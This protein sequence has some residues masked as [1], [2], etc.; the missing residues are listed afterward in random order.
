MVDVG[1]DF[2]KVGLTGAFELIRR[3]RREQGYLLMAGIVNGDDR[4]ISGLRKT[5]F[6]RDPLDPDIPYGKQCKKRG[7]MWYAPT[8]GMRGMPWIECVPQDYIR[9]IRITSTL[10]AVTM[11]VTGCETMSKTLTYETEHGS[12]TV[13]FTNTS[14]TIHI[15]NPHH[16]TPN[17]PHVYSF[18][19]R[20]GEDEIS[21]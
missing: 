12:E 6:V 2:L 3:H 5:V 10:D 15:S 18:T 21:S 11:T 1:H 4:E 19:I 8:S 20:C 14:V 16:W 9:D 17:D 13:S 7:G